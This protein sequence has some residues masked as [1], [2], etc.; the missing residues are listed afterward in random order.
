MQIKCWISCQELF[1]SFFLFI[2]MLYIWHWPPLI[3]AK[4][5]S[6]VKYLTSQLSPKSLCKLESDVD[7]KNLKIW[8]RREIFFSSREIYK[9]LGTHSIYFHMINWWYLCCFFNEHNANMLCHFQMYVYGR[10]AVLTKPVIFATAFMSFFSVVIALFKVNY[11]SSYHL[12][13][14]RNKT[15]SEINIK[16]LMSSS[17]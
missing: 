3:W 10:P 15:I 7:N 14:N 16:N 11:L 2:E 12:L 9:V 1:F 5:S 6:F 17:W 4:M 13:K 8:T